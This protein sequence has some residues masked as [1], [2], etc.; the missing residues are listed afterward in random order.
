[1]LRSSLNIGELRQGFHGKIWGRVAK[2]KYYPRMAR[3]RGLEGKPIVAFTLGTNGELVDLKLAK[4]S[5]Y[6][7]LN[8]AALETIRRG[9]PYPPIPKTL[10]RNSISFNLPISYVLEK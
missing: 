1:M 8:D 5:S 4:A 6:D 10:G 2:V 9:I 3:K 7:L